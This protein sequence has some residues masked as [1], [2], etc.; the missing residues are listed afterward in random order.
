VAA[1]LAELEASGRRATLFVTTDH[2]RS[3]GFSGHGGSSPESAEVWLVASGWGIAPRGLVS[4]DG[5]RRLADVASTIRMLSGVG[6]PTPAS[7][8]L[9]ELLDSE[10]SQLIASSWSNPITTAATAR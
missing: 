10:P 9:S 6:L 7:A 4:G 1:A 5:T 3:A 8:P 2:G